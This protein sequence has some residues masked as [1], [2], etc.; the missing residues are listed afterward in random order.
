MFL[1]SI[2]GN[3]EPSFFIIRLK[4]DQAIEVCAR[5]NEATF[6]HEY[7]H[8][9][10]D[11]ILPYCIRQNLVHLAKFFDQ[12]DRVQ[13][14]AEI[15]MPET[16]ELPEEAIA[17]LHSKM[18]WGSGSFIESIRGITSIEKFA[19][20]VPEHNH[21]VYRYELL[22]EGGGRYHIGARD[23]LEYIAYKIESKHYVTEEKLADFPYRSVDLLCQHYGITSLNDV[24]KVA[25]AEHCLHNDDPV[26]RLMILLAETAAQAPGK[27][28]KISDEGFM[29][30][31][32][33]AN[34]KAAGVP[35]ETIAD[36][37]N[38]RLDELRIFL[39]E[40]YPVDAFPEIAAWLDRTMEY[41]RT[42]LAGR[43]LFAELYQ[44]DTPEFRTA[45]SQILG[46]VGV[47]LIE[48]GYGEL[49]TSL[50]GD[51][52]RGQ[53]IQLLLA[54][55]FSHYLR[56]NDLQCPLYGVCERDRP[57]IMDDNCMDGPFRRAREDEL[58]PFGAFAKS[59]QL[60]RVRWYANGRLIS[61]E[62][63]VW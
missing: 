33:K 24:K 40:K 46:A 27:L 38:R 60:D 57:N 11:L 6:T 43:S 7:I 35:F 51:G 39:L 59:H 44:A 31:L 18:T 26:N 52:T 3:Y 30:L 12:M 34:W 16:A 50:G 21:N 19:Q 36:K 56:R 9:L 2:E 8:F 37:L 4:T 10:Q 13:K 58:C 29:L 54:F 20:F 32:Q 41:A 17:S 48:N 22:L 23:L 61:G 45:L 5:E 63:S 42:D 15:R 53:F 28:E 1:R 49:G 25:L 55:E 14:E 62:G 47:P